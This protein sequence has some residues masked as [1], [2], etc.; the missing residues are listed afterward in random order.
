MIRPKSLQ[1]R[2]SFYVMLPVSLLL[3]MMGVSGFMYARKILISEWQVAAISQ[4]QMAAHQV[5]ML[6]EPIKNHIMSLDADT[7]LTGIPEDVLDWVIHRLKRQKGVEQVTL[8]WKDA[9]ASSEISPF[10]YCPGAD[11]ARALSGLTK[12]PDIFHTMN[13]LECACMQDVT[14]PRFGNVVED[15]TISLV[16]DVLDTSG[17]TIGRL[18]VIIDF[19]YLIHNIKEMGWW[20]NSKAFL[21]DDTGKILGRAVFTIREVSQAAD[22]VAN[23]IYKSS[24]PVTD[25]DEVGELALSFNMMVSQLKERMH[26]KEALNLA[27]EVQQNLLPRSSLH[28]KG[29]E[30]AGKSQYCEET[31]GDYFDFLLPAKTADG[32]VGVVVGD[33]VGRGVS[34]ALLMTTG[35]ALLRCRLS[36]PGDLAEALGDINQLLCRDTEASGSFMTLLCVMFDMSA[37][38][39]KWVRAG[40]DPGLLYDSADDTFRELTG[41]GIALGVNAGCIYQENSLEQL[42]NGQVFIFDALVKSRFWDGFVKSSQAR[43]AN[44]QGVRRTFGYAATTKDAAQR[45]IR[46]FYEVVIFGTDGVWE[47]RNGAGRMFGKKRLMDIIRQRAGL[48]ADEMVAAMMQAVNDFI[49][50]VRQEDD[51]TLVVAR[52]VDG[53]FP[54]GSS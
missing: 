16:S 20:R 54:E 38:R 19:E 28:V 48:S 40:H 13:L 18:E 42:K 27:M 3:V 53:H 39:V 52:V 17:K 24:L 25:G 4:L 37:G 8:T 9:S 10:T 30:I 46:T 7:G 41:K 23:G 5:D 44:P 49:S 2:L 6:I 51:I 47:A 33:V 35:R 21:V 12:P 15:K 1:Q 29:L 43:R 22:K 26:L 11:A 34:A 36:L 45:S 31:G 50:S 14:P 32:Q